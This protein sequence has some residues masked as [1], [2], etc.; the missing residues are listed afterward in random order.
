M[1]HS[2][3][4]RLSMRSPTGIGRSHLPG[5]KMISIGLTAQSREPISLSS[6][7]DL[8]VR[9]CDLMAPRQPT[10]ALAG[11]RTKN[12]Y[13]ANL[14][15]TF[16]AERVDG[17][18]DIGGNP[19]GDRLAPPTRPVLFGGGGAP[20]P[21]LL[22]P[23]APNKLGNQPERHDFPGSQPLPPNQLPRPAQR[24]VPGT[25][26]IPLPPPPTTAPAPTTTPAPA[27]APS[28]KPRSHSCP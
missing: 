17:R 20:A 12:G 9:R 23:P 27:P 28:L 1:A 24:A 14:P 18:L 4:R 6:H 16:R 8:Q 5:C 3:C 2:I 13:I 15:Y 7:Q 26:A 11:P 10:I 25:G 22:P 19:S 21:N